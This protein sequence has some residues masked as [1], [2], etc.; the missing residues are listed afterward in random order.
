MLQGAIVEHLSGIHGKHIIRRVLKRQVGK[1]WEISVGE[2][3]AQIHKA[4]PKAEPPAPNI[5]M[6]GE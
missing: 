4:I 1:H 6:W 3:N 5:M 2:H